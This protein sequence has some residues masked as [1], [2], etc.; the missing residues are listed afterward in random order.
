MQDLFAFTVSPWELIVRATAMYWFIYLLFRLILRRDVGSIAIA[1]VLLLVLIA[2]AAQNGMDG[3]YKTIPEGMVVIATLAFWNLA[4]DYA[5]FKSKRLRKILEP[6]S[7]PLIVDGQL[8]R[9]NMRK[10]LITSDELKAELRAKGIE[11]FEDVKMG[12]LESDGEITLVLK[13]DPG[14]QSE[15]SKPAGAASD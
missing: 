8:Q 15:K 5:C 11:H 6:K 7:L 3:D 9:Q 12:R 10:Q 2:D 4:L 14:I 1:D 13:R